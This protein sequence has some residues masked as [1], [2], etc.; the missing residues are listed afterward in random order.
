MRSAVSNTPP[1]AREAMKPR[2]AL[3]GSGKARSFCC[4]MPSLG[5]DAQSRSSGSPKAC[6]VLRQGRRRRSAY[7]GL[8]LALLSRSVRLRASFLALLFL[9]PPAF[10]CF[11][12]L[13]LH[14]AACAW[15]GRWSP[16]LC[17]GAGNRKQWPCCKRHGESG[18]KHQRSRKGE[19]SCR[20][21]HRNF[22]VV[23]GQP[24]SG[25]GKTQDQLRAASRRAIES[26]R[27]R[28]FVQRTALPFC[29]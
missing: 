24:V 10:P 3:S 11:P 9:T 26:R 13:A 7:A 15:W 21:D 4:A 2:F 1:H 14:V 5:Q 20:P 16:H 18:C 25:L 8:L 12:A 17:L 29:C 19:S 23:N 28:I 6:G 27:Q 22:L